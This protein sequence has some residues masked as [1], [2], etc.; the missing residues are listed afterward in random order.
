[1]AGE[2]GTHYLVEQAGQVRRVIGGVQRCEQVPVAFQAAGSQVGG[3]V[4][5]TDEAAH[6]TLFGQ[7]TQEVGERGA[8]VEAAEE[9]KMWG[10]GATAHDNGRRHGF[11]P[12][13]GDAVPGAGQVGTHVWLLARDGF[14]E[15]E[16]R[17]QPLQV[18]RGA[19]LEYATQERIV[20]WGPV[21]VSLIE[22]PPAS[23]E[24][25]TFP[26]ALGVGQAVVEVDKRHS[27]GSY[28]KPARC[29]SQPACTSSGGSPASRSRPRMP[30][31]W[32]RASCASATF[33]PF[34]A[35]SR[36]SWAN[37]S[38]AATA[39]GVSRSSSIAVAKVLRGPR[40]LLGRPSPL[41][42]VSASRSRLAC[43]AAFCRRSG[44]C[45]QGWR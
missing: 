34:L 27:I 12:T 37:C 10:R 26:T 1:V 23:Q 18:G 22:A 14:G 29:R 8:V 43:S 21:A 5:G 20:G 7:R 31:M 36:I 13:A 25:A 11:L 44:L 9:G 19:R 28:I 33:C 2:D 45:A 39:V 17:V 41:C 42:T 15:I 38:R 30:P 32:R 35:A 40:M 6:A 3:E 16:R 4:N 24:R